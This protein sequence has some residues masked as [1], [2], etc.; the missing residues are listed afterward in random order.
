VIAKIVQRNVTSV[1][2]VDLQHIASNTSNR[3]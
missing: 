2:P 3:G 1:F